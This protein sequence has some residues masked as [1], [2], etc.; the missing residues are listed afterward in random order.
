[1]LHVDR[2]FDTATLRATAMSFEV[3]SEDVIRLI[4]QF[5]KVLCGR[6]KAPNRCRYDLAPTPDVLCLA[7][8]YFWQRC[9]V[10]E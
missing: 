5:L 7:S 3:E 6:P 2:I 10:E 4:L 1:M 9:T 8:A